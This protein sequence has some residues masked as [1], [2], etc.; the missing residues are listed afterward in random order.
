MYWCRAD[1]P[2]LYAFRTPLG[3]MCLGHRDRVILDELAMQVL[4]RVHR[5]FGN[6]GLV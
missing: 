5:S 1:R 4:E 3:E 2:G 6:L